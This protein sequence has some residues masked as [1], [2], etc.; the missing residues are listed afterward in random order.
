MLQEQIIQMSF[1]NKDIILSLADRYKKKTRL[2]LIQDNISNH[3]MS[4]WEQN[5]L[6]LIIEKAFTRNLNYVK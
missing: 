5:T 4:N 3:Q 2:S 6:S 1:I